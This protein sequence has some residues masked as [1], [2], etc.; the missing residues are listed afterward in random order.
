MIFFSTCFVLLKIRD[1]KLYFSY[2]TNCSHENTLALTKKIKFALSKK[3]L[4]SFSIDNS[5]PLDNFLWGILSY[6]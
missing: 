2:C 1:Q 3:S 5:L 4:F 6:I